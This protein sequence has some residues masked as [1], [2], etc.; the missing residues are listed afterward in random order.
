MSPLKIKSALGSLCLGSGLFT[1][2]LSR[3]ARKHYSLILMY[4]RILN[5]QDVHGSIEPGMYVTPD[6]FDMHLQFLTK[7]FTVV[8]LEQVIGHE[9]YI[10]NNKPLCALTFDDGWLDFKTNAFTLLKKYSVPATVFLPTDYIGTNK[11]FWTD[12]IAMILNNLL[13]KPF[14]KGT[15]IERSTVIAQI[16]TLQGDFATKIDNAIRI[17][18]TLDP[19]QIAY[20]MRV[21]VKIANVAPCN[22]PRSFLNWDEVADLKGSGLVSFGSH[23]VHHHLLTSLQP[24]DVD[25]ELVESQKTILEKRVANR[26]FMSFCYPNGNVTPQIAGQTKKAGYHLAVSTKTGWCAQYIDRYVLNRV[27]IH[28]DISST[29]GLLAFRILSTFHRTC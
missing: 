20:T 24:P 6:T 9:K 28:Q 12:E 14:D 13:V 21:L 15:K 7:H 25:I 29:E 10:A 4:H 2:Q 1:W 19:N 18:K 27:G 17:I 3:A 5:P 11:I 8:P 22:S 26:A 16:L 23:T